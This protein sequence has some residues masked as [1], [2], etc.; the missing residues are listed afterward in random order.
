MSGVILIATNRAS[1]QAL[2]KDFGTPG[3]VKKVYVAR[4]SGKFPR[5]DVVPVSDDPFLHLEAGEVVCDEPLLTIDKQIGVN[6]V[7]ADG[8]VSFLQSVSATALT[9]FCSQAA[10]SSNVCP[11]MQHLTHRSSD[12]VQSRVDRIKYVCTCSI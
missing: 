7:H 4:V 1:A 10:P 6:V 5:S 8:R 2:G 12:V 11:T 9:V 3:R